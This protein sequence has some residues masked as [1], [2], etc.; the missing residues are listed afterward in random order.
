MKALRLFF[1][2]II[3]VAIVMAALSMLM[4]VSQTVER[5]ITVNAPASLIYQQLVK[6]EN[7]NKYSV[8]GQGD[9]SAKYTLTGKDG[10]V[11]AASSWTGDPEIS[12][13]GKI[14]ITGLEANK[15][16]NHRLIFTQPKKGSAESSFILNEINGTTS[17]T[18]HFELATPRPWNIFNLFYSLDKKM[19]KDFDEGLSLLKTGIEKMNGTETKETFAVEEMNFPATSFAIVRQKVKWPDLLPFFA[20]HLPLVAQEANNAGVTPG[21]ASGLIYEWDEKNQLADIAAAVPVPAD[22]KIS[23]PIVLVVNLPASKA[24]SVTYKGAYDKSPA[25]YASLKKYMADNKLKENSPSI[26][27]YLIGP[28][29]EKDT[30]KWL[31]KVL[32]LVE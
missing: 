5:T 29:N 2:F 3:S 20:E 16:V 23:S 1:F 24:I 18:W 31:T 26:E 13:D 11:G 17:V 10:T 30:A 28:A 15:K 9:P 8:W 6:L 21:T 25:V 32:Y 7:F 12:G 4:P 14:E 27:Q 19:G 22:T